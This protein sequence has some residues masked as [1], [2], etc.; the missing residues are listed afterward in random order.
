M[1]TYPIEVGN[2]QCDNIIAITLL[3]ANAVDVKMVDCLV[4]HY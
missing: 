4:S 3:K 2:C 1:E